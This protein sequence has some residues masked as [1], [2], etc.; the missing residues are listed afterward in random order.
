MVAIEILIAIKK[1]PRIT[2]KEISHQTGIS[3]QYIRNTLR[4][5]AEL[6]LVETPARGNYVITPKGETFITK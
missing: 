1:T 5:L 3:T 2:A 6:E 4:L